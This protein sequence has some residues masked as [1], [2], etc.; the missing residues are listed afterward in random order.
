MEFPNI[1]LPTSDSKKMKFQRKVRL[2]Q[3][4]RLRTKLQA[5][6]VPVASAYAINKFILKNNTYRE[7]TMNKIGAFIA[8]DIAGEYISDYIGGRPLAILS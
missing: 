5:K 1:P 4:H 8:A 7:N 2:T 3:L 6:E